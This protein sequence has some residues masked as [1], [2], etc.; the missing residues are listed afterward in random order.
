MSIYVLFV[1]HLSERIFFVQR[2]SINAT[3]WNVIG[4][5]I[6]FFLSFHFRKNQAKDLD[7]FSPSIPSVNYVFHASISN[8][9]SRLMKKVCDSLIDWW[10]KNIKS[11]YLIFYGQIIKVDQEVLATQCGIKLPRINEILCCSCN[12]IVILPSP[13]VTKVMFIIEFFNMRNWNWNCKNWC[14][15]SGNEASSNKTSF[16]QYLHLCFCQYR[17]GEI[18]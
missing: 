7:F 11:G 2:S 18:L 12:V 4:Y 10:K 15:G 9:T 16:L 5:L 13:T 3:K 6:F 17:S 8:K 14:M 1:I